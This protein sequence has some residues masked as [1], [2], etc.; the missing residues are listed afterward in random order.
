MCDRFV[1]LV[2]EMA[3]SSL[4]SDSAGRPWAAA[5]TQPAGDTYARAPRRDRDAR[6]SRSPALPLIAGLTN[7]VAIATFARCS[8]HES[9]SPYCRRNEMRKQKMHGF[10][11][12]GFA[13]N[14]VH[15]GGRTYFSFLVRHAWRIPGR[16]SHAAMVVGMM[17]ASLGCRASTEHVRTP[18]SGLHCPDTQKS[19][20][21]KESLH[22]PVACNANP[23][24]STEEL[25]LGIHQSKKAMQ[26]SSEVRRLQT[27]LP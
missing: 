12:G 26:L 24:R 6:L 10:Y 15:G 11:L 19:Q 3:P 25:L 5:R 14:R 7:P 17:A 8:A 16:A 21:K 20:S 13:A 23:R 2:A 27:G 4:T 1:L 9:V 18:T 22:K